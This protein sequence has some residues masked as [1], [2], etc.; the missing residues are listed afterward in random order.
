MPVAFSPY[1]GMVFAAGTYF[2]GK[3]GTGM[4][5]SRIFGELQTDYPSIWIQR[6]QAL[7]MEGEFQMKV[8]ESQRLVLET[9]GLRLSIF[10]TGLQVSQ[11]SVDSLRVSGPLQRLDWEVLE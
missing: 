6:D 3:G 7:W 11:L 1:L 10:G 5:H 4:E 9:Q 8:L 2:E